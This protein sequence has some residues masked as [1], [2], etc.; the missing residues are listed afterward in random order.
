VD[1]V[2]PSPR[3]DVRWLMIVLGIAFLVFAGLLLAA[4]SIVTGA[5][6]AGCAPVGCSATNPGVW[7]LWAALPFLALGLGL[8]GTGLW[9]AFR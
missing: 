9:W 2:I 8:L 5:V 6:D 3:T 1:P 7:F 4:S